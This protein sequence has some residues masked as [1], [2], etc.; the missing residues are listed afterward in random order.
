MESSQI[1]FGSMYCGK[2]EE[3]KRRIKRYELAGK[4]CV[5]FK[6]SLDDRY[7]EDTILTHD[8]AKVI[9]SI[10]EN[11]ENEIKKILTKHLGIPACAVNNSEELLTM[12]KNSKEKIDVVGID[13]VQFFDE[14]IIQ[15]IHELNK[16]DIIVVMSALDLF[17]SGEPLPITKELVC[18]C[19]Y[20]DKLH[21]VCKHC[22][23]EAAYSFKID[24]N[25]D[26]VNSK[27]DIGS[28]GKYIALCEECR[29]KELQK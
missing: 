20:A 25:K 26:N 16:M 5:L 17:A 22:G 14:G 13:E 2:T 9:K 10:P 19:K 3:L 23:K 18:L 29:E 7:S 27:I 1:I 15:V 11:I 8:V 24:D 21:A 4:N 6:P 12:V 28:E